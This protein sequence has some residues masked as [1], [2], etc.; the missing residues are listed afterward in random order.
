MIREI[1]IESM[2]SYDYRSEGTVF[3]K[4]AADQRFRHHAWHYHGC[5]PCHL[6]RHLPSHK[7]TVHLTTLRFGH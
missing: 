1:Q 4:V 6:L 5:L 2:S 7:V 3:S